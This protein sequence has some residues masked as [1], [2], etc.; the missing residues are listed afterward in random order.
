[1]DSLA[2]R[3]GGRVESEGPL[4]D[5]GL[6]GDAAGREQRDQTRVDALTSKG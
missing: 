5:G 6:E 1:M 2:A 4:W 3:F